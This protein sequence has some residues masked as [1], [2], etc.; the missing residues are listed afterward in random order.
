MPPSCSLVLPGAQKVHVWEIF[1]DFPGGLGVID[2][3]LARE[4]AFK[5]EFENQ[6]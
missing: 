5:T 3:G 2:F 6:R 1:F 4:T